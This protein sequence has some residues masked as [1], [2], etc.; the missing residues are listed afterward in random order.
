MNIEQI[1]V[2]LQKRFGDVETCSGSNGV[3]YKVRCC[4]CDRQALSCNPEKRVFKCWHCGFKGKLSYL[5][6]GV[7]FTSPISVKPRHIKKAEYVSPGKALLPLT[8]AS[9]ECLDYL[10]SREQDPKYLE[11]AFDFKYCEIGK[12]FMKGLYD[13]TDTIIIPIYDINHKEVGWQ[14]RLLYDPQELSEEECELNG[15][16]KKESGK[17]KRPPKYMTMPGFKKSKTFWNIQQA[18]KSDVAVICEGVFDSVNVGKCGIA[19]FG[20][21]LSAEQVNIVKTNWEYVAILLDP[22]AGDVLTK[23]QRMLMSTCFTTVVDIRPYK[24]AGAANRVFIWQKIIESF[25]SAKINL[26]GL[27]VMI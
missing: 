16:S 25:N 2:E 9:K 14:S 22:D 10:H 5:L 17:H 23:T 6:K 7:V 8:K 3:E 15:W 11:Q 21:E 24:D 20:K 1:K 18:I 27:K 4:K 26:K 19:A 13:T 12:T